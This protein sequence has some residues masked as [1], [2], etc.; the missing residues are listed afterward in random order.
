MTE[1]SLNSNTLHCSFCGKSQH[2]VRKLIAGAKALICDECIDLCNTIMAE[3]IG[4]TSPD[5]AAI[6][7]NAKSQIRI[8]EMMGGYTYAVIHNP[9]CPSS[10]QVRLPNG[11]LDYK[12]LGQSLDSIGHGATEVEAFRS[13]LEERNKGNST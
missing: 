10:Y 2:E 9:N 5:Y 13:A 4:K 6:F 8:R 3:E 11:V 12:P 1:S 7:E